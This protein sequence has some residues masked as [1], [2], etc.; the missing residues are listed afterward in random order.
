MKEELKRQI[1]KE[2]REN[3]P[4]IWVLMQDIIIADRQLKTND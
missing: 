2:V 1:E 3:F 4:N